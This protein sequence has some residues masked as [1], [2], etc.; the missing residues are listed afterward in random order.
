MGEINLWMLSGCQ[1]QTSWD[2]VVFQETLSCQVFSVQLLRCDRFHVFFFSRLFPVF[3][4]ATFNKF[5]TTDAN[6]WQSE[7]ATASGGDRAI[8]SLGFEMFCGCVA[9]W[10]AEATV[11]KRFASLPLF[12]MNSSLCEYYCFW[13]TAV[14]DTKTTSAIF[15]LFSEH[16]LIFSIL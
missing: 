8:R 11:S 2:A 16:N 4:S 6:L 5:K 13:I 15:P 9:F 1:I 12:K 7:S 3:P 10:S 14:L